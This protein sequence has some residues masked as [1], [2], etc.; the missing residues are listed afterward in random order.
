M[1]SPRAWYPIAQ[2]GTIQNESEVHGSDSF[3][4]AQV[5]CVEGVMEVRLQRE[6]I[7]KLGDR[8]PVRSGLLLCTRKEETKE[9]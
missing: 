6:F 4:D 3:S 1:T 5:C 8:K 7:R 2:A 9:R